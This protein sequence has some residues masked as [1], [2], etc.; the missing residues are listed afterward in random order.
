MGGGRGGGGGGGVGGGG[1]REIRIGIRT[2]A[3]NRVGGGGAGGRD[4]RKGEREIDT[5]FVCVHVA[6]IIVR[7]R[8]VHV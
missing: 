5:K 7:T 4:E 1:S 6:F 2:H 3:E 8:H